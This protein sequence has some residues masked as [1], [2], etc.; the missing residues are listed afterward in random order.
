MSL[1]QPAVLAV[2]SHASLR[3]RKSLAGNLNVVCAGLPPRILFA[4]MLPRTA[5][6]LS[7]VS[8]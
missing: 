2:P 6:L 8:I 7:T 5:N 3:I 1:S 4:F